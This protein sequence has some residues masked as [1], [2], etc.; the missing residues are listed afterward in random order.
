[1]EN[2][3]IEDVKPASPDVIEYEKGGIWVQDWLR[4]TAVHA[5]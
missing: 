5:Q 2:L 1:M 4:Y 3:K